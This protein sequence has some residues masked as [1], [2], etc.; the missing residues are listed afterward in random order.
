MLFINWWLMT[1]STVALLMISAGIIGLSKVKNQTRSLA[2]VG[3]RL[4]CIPLTGLGTLVGLLL[5]L[6]TTSGCEKRSSPI[7][8]PSGHVAVR[9]YDF[10]EGAT[11]GGTSVEMFWARGFR[12]ATVFT[13]PWKAV[14]PGD[15]HWVSDSEMTLSYRADAPGDQY[16]CTS[17]AVVKIVCI[18]K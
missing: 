11:G 5:L 10:D 7:Y 9:V 1:E 16:Y 8:S 13:G 6:V 12:Q 2:R 4:I 14:E 3:I 18:P 17:A 15:I